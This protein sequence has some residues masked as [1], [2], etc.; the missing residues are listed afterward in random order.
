MSPVVM[1]DA[2]S[3]Q[4]QLMVVSLVWGVTPHN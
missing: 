1:V 2:T 3:Y 4:E